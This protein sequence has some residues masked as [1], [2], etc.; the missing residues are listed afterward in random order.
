MLLN[1]SLAKGK[2]PR[3]SPVNYSRRKKLL[4]PKH[5]ET[6]CCEL[7]RRQDCRRKKSG[8]DLR[9]NKKM[10]FKLP[11]TKSNNL[12]RSLKFNSHSCQRRT[13]RPRKWSR[14]ASWWL[15]KRQK[16]RLTWQHSRLNAMWMAKTKYRQIRR[17]SRNPYQLCMRTKTSHW[18]K[19]RCWA[20]RSRVTGR[21]NRIVT[22]R[23]KTLR[24]SSSS[25]LRIQALLP[26]WLH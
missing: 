6:R 15:S 24:A 25:L 19:T 16:K 5:R 26:K 2:L 1:L 4:R 9:N 7:T 11:K 22:T 18:T 14:C 20:N 10:R 21:E 8:R 3:F 12:R 13:R 17:W 23:S